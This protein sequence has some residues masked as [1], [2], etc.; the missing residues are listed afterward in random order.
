MKGP[1]ETAQQQIF[2]CARCMNLDENTTELLRHPLREITVSIPVLMDD[3]RVKI[4]T[5][6]R[7]HY[8][9]ALGPMKG[10]VRYHPDETIDTIRALAAWMTWK[11]ALFDLPLGGAKGGII[12]DPKNLSPGEL[13]QLTRGYIDRIWQFIGPDMDIPA[14][15]V[16]TDARIMGWMMDEYS[17]LSGKNQPGIVTGKPIR[18]GGSLGRIEATARG[19]ITVIREAARELNLDLR[20]ATVVIQGFGNV[21][22]NAAYM[23]RNILNARVIAVSDSRGGVYSQ[24]GLNLEEVSH[25]KVQTGSVVGSPNTARVDSEDLLTLK[26]DIVIAAALEH[27]ITA[28][29]AERMSPRILAEFANGPTTPDADAI[30]FERDVHIIPDILCNAGGVTV[31]FFEMVQ[32]KTMLP[33]TEEEVNRRLEKRMVKA[34]DEVISTARTQG[35]DMRRAAY[36]VAVSRVVDAMRLRGRLKK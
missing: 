33:W 1:Y 8:N 5:G 20:G 13:E 10:G 6:F 27:A 22:G 11:C 23:V 14:P 24:E 30:L 31:S 18:I 26:A 4:F 21:G 29:R 35:I 19:G 32:N 34:Y 7:I 9:D 16:G 2:D 12:C 15:D 17:N 36:V 3:G 25:Q 28:E